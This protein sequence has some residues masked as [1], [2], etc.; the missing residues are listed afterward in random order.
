MRSRRRPAPSHPPRHT[1]SDRGSG[2]IHVLTAC[3]L[4]ST[5]LAAAILWATISTAR[6]QL[7][8][9]ADLTALSAANSLTS[10]P[11]TT[12]AQTATANKVTLTTCTPTPTDITI[13][14]SL[15]IPLP[16]LPTPTLTTT[17]RA[18]RIP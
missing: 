8:A 3:L 7:A 4:L 1:R 11:C 12:A 2:T 14:V 17:S 9:A 13:Q 6:H 5:A 10:A 18:G 15:P 16:F